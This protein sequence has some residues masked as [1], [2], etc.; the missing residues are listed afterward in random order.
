V[1]FIGVVPGD[2]MEVAPLP[3]VILYFSFTLIFLFIA[4]VFQEAIG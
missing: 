3:N 1:T 2:F 4:L